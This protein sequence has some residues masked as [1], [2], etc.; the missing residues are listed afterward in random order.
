M[1]IILSL[2]GILL[3]CMG[4]LLY[5]YFSYSYRTVYESCIDGYVEK[6]GGKAEDYQTYCE[7]FLNRTKEA[8]TETEYK[9]WAHL[10]R[11]DRKQ[12]KEISLARKELANSQ[13][14]CFVEHAS[15]R[16]WSETFIRIYTDVEKLPSEVASC[17]IRE[18][19]KQ[20]DNKELFITLVQMKMQLME[21]T[22]SFKKV[23]QKIKN[24]CISNTKT[25]F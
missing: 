3:I 17:I 9:E 24:T 5:G 10:Y 8:L 2:F 14:G 20:K 15:I 23:E 19:V 1:E 21:Q 22:E 7:C 16:M 6:L 18:F 13:F 11:T 4:C 25:F 12:A